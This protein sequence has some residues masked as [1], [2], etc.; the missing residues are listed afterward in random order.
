MIPDAGG[1]GLSYFGSFGSVYGSYD[2]H[3]QVLR[4]QH[5]C[6][7]ELHLVLFLDRYVLRFVLLRPHQRLGLGC[8]FRFL[9]AGC[10]D[11]VDNSL[12]GV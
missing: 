11:L 9:V 6:R 5:A 2:V 1:C 7:V 3:V 8:L 12:F 10:T 4:D